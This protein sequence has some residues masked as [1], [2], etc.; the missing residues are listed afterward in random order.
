MKVLYV[1]FLLLLLLL[2]LCDFFFIGEPQFEASKMA[3]WGFLN[4]K[5]LGGV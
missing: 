5:Q 4:C 2:L 1:I 3:F